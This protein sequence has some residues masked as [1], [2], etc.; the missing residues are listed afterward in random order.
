MHI[1]KYLCFIL[2]CSVSALFAK[3]PKD[4]SSKVLSAIEEYKYYSI[5][6]EHRFKYPMEKDT[7]FELYS[8]NVYKIAP[9]RYIG[10]HQMSYLRSGTAR[11]IVAANEEGIHRVNF[12]ENM[13]YSTYWKENDKLMLQNLKGNLY[14]TFLYSKEYI[15]G[16]TEYN[17]DADYHYLERTDSVKNGKQ[18]LISIAK[19]LLRVDRNS[20][21]IVSEE[22][23]STAANGNVQY[24]LYSINNIVLLDKK[25]YTPLLKTTDSFISVIH[26]YTNGDS[27]KKSRRELYRKLKTGD[28]ATFFKAEA[29]EGKPFDMAINSDS[30]LI[31]DFFYS[32]CKPCIAGI[33]ELN[34]LYDRFDSLG[35]SVYGLNTLQS[36]WDKMESYVKTYGVKYTLLKTP[37]QVAYDY[38][39]TGY[40]RL[41]IVKNGI[42]VK[43]YFGFTKGMEK[44]ISV[45]I[46]QLMFIK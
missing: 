28:T 22:V 43:I 9:D 1:H 39:V 12:R 15:E 41:F 37:T 40:P 11:A 27:V 31:F 7:L 38:G 24:S 29:F 44:E 42:I 14:K 13:Y 35:V 45:L 4:L 21:L 3:L 33:P 36:D 20:F 16:F 8:S 10:W 5:Q 2:F 30:I 26:T 17:K 46:K 34:L 18:Q 23:N 19:T 32:T 25:S 6:Y